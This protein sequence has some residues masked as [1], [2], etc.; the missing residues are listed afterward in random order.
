MG[1]FDD[2]REA[3][4]RRRRNT[5]GLG[6]QYRVAW[7]RNAE[8]VPDLF[9]AQLVHGQCRS[10]NAA[11]GVRNAQ[12]LQQALHAAVF[13]ATTVEN[14]EGAVDFFVEQTL[15]QV[16]AHVETERVHAGA[17]QRV[18]NRVT[19]L[20]GYLT[21]GTLAAEQHGDAAEIFRR[22]RGDEVGVSSSH[23]NFPTLGAATAP[24]NN[25]LFNSFGA[26]PP[27]SPAPWHSRMSPARSS[28]LTTGARST[29]RSM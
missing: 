14:D 26:R 4:F 7:R 10:Q 22:D 24:A 21:L 19:R 16:I 5:I 1:R 13:T 25:G 3:Q 20:Q 12:A 2:Q 9:G 6:T 11:A 29:P 18:E 17:L 8:A 28:G 23:F 27:I 15:Q